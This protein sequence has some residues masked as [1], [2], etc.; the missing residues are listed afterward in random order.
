MER[1]VIVGLVGGAIDP[2]SCLQIRTLDFTWKPKKNTDRNTR[3]CKS[4]NNFIDRY[5]RF[6]IE[7][8][9]FFIE[10]DTRFCIKVAISLTKRDTR[11]CIKISNFYKNW[12]CRP[13]LTRLVAYVLDFLLLQLLLLL[14]LSFKIY[15]HNINALREYDRPPATQLRWQ[16]NTH[17][18]SP[19]E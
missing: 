9:I 4:R 6:C 3:F 13:I 19:K 1:I 5:S 16:H 18:L 17:F 15:P 2:W 7:V 8:G 14:I 10:W 11:F 12:T